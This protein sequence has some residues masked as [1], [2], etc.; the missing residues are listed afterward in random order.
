MSDKKYLSQGH[1]LFDT[2]KDETRFDVSKSDKGFSYWINRPYVSDSLKKKLVTANVLFVPHENFRDLPY[3]VFPVQTTELYHLIEDHNNSAITA[4]IC[5][6]D[7]NYKELA[8]HADIIEIATFVVQYSVF[9]ILAGLITN[10]LSK[11]LG[12]RIEKAHV[13]SKIFVEK[14]NQTTMIDYD[15]P[16]STF[17]KTINSLFQE[18]VS[19]SSSLHES[20]EMI[21]DE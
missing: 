18:N 2:E 19:K 7:D 3:P 1:V 8:V 17:E 14:E 21:S 13:R 4:D 11:R 5:I 16:A 9:P 20:K 12:K 6:E 10:Y 15:G